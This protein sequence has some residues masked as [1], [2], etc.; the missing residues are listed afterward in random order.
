MHRPFAWRPTSTMRIARLIA[1]KRWQWWNS[2]LLHELTIRSP[3]GT[4]YE[5][6]I[7]ERRYQIR[8]S[9]RHHIHD[10]PNQIAA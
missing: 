10:H 2:P 9:Y 5:F 7:Q 8:R 6:R 3:K 4:V 1:E